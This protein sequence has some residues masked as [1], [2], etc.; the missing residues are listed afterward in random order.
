VVSESP[1]LVECRVYPYFAIN[2]KNA[3][4]YL[5]PISIAIFVGTE[6]VSNSEYHTLSLYS[7]HNANIDFIVP[8]YTPKPHENAAW[9]ILG[10]PV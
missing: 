3:N 6:F 10:I 7:E 5:L 1:L 9:Y 4:L 8:I 2:F